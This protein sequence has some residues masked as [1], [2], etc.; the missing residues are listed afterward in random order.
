MG[1]NFL[2]F[3]IDGVLIKPSRYRKAVY[4]TT[5]YFLNKLGFSKISINEEIIT[6]FESI[7]ITSEWDIVQL[8][9]L[10]VTEL[11]LIENQ[12][13]TTLENFQDCYNFFRKYEFQPDQKNVISSVLSP[14]RYSSRWIFCL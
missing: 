5:S 1:T 14:E 7:G 9:L 4:D 8:F 12:P 6:T 11:S 13:D 10:I 2:L 3:D